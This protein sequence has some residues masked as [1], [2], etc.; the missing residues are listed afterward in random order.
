VDVLRG[1]CLCG[2]VR[3]EVTT[4]FG[5]VT[6]CHCTSCKKLSGGAGTVNGRVEPQAVRIL[7]GEE[8]LERYQPPD[9]SAKTFC[10]RCGSNLFGGGWP[11][12]ERAS[13]RLSALD[14][15]FDHPPDLH[16]FTRSVAAWET[17]PDD[18]KP[19]YPERAP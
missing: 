11:E 6:Q 19:R 7:D 10:R 12:G 8:L 2:S 9:G 3:F 5:A 17:L 13:I 16:I 4:P 15:H 1:S 14:D 18:G